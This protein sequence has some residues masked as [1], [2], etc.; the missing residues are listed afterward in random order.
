M[1]RLLTSVALALLDADGL[2]GTIVFHTV[3]V[4]ME[5]GDFLKTLAGFDE[6]R[7]T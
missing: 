7:V 5:T 2:G 3:E 1:E 4:Q 6:L